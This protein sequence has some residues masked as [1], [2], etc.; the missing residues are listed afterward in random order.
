MVVIHTLWVDSQRLRAEARPGL[1]Q[2]HNIQQYFLYR[3]PGKPVN[4]RK[5]FLKQ[6]NFKTSRTSKRLKINLRGKKI[7]VE[8]ML[9]VSNELWFQ[10]VEQYKLMRS[11][12]FFVSKC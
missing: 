6:D 9:D 5:K 2:P 11:C 7:L 12:L 4:I 10:I 1:A 8:Y 3:G